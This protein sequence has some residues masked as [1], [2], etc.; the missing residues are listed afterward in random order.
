MNIILS[1]K[2]ILYFLA[3]FW[4]IFSVVYIVNN[5]WSNYKN[6][7]LLQ[8]Y[9]QGRIDTINTLIRAAEKCEPIPVF[10]EE[11]EIELIRMDCLEFPTE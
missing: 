1:K 7:Q 3:F 6:F 8:A 9:E 11:R 4:I 2:I 10:S 5:I